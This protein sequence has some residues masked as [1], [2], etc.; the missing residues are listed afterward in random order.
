MNPRFQENLNFDIK[1]EFDYVSIYI[2]VLN[3]L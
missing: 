2:F 1:F 3:L